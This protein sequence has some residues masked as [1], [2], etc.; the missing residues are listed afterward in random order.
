MKTPKSDADDRQVDLEAGAALEAHAVDGVGDQAELERH[1]DVAAGELRRKPSPSPSAMTSLPLR[2]DV[3]EAARV[4]ADLDAEGEARRSAS[5]VASL[6][7]DD[8]GRG[9]SVARPSGAR[10]MPSDGDAGPKAREAGD[11]V[12]S[13]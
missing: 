4:A 8:E 10:P 6:G 1:L 12:E 3:P 7:A 5:R 13:G 11:A 9:V 2:T